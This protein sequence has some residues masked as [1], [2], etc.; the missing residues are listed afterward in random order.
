MDGVKVFVQVKVCFGVG[1]PGRW[2]WRLVGINVCV[3]VWS[4][5]V[6]QIFV[7]RAEV[8]DS[9]WSRADRASAPGDGLSDSGDEDPSFLKESVVG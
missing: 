5:S 9:Q 8:V 6:F 7:R 3:R 2:S 4:R 1:E